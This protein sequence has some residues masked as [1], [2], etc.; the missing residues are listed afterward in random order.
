MLMLKPIPQQLHHHVRSP[1][2]L[3]LN[4]SLQMKAYN[5]VLL[6]GA[7]VMLHAIVGMLR[8]AVEELLIQ[9]DYT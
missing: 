8:V 6:C 7:I 9:L 5:L 4:L 3:H 1:S 2:F